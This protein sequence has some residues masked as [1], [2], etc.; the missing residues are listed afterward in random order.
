[1][2]RIKQ[3]E[4]GE[5]KDV[6]GD[7]VFF[8]GNVLEIQRVATGLWSLDRAFSGYQGE[9]GLPITSIELF[10]PTGAGKSS[11]SYSLAAMVCAATKKHLVL[12]DLEGFDPMTLKDILR[13]SGYRGPVYIA[14]GI[15]PDAVLDSMLEH[16][17]KKDVIAAIVDSVAA[18]SPIGEINSK[19][20]EANMGKRAKLVTTEQRKLIN[21]LRGENKLAIHI[22]HQ[23]P[24]LGWVGTTTPG[25]LGLHY[26]SAIRIAITCKK[27]FPDGGSFVISG[28]VKKNRYGYKDRTFEAVFLVGKGLD[29]NL[30]AIWDCYTQKILYQKGKEKTLRW[31]ETDESIQTLASYAKLSRAGE[32]DAFR[33]FYDALNGLSPESDSTHDDDT[34]EDTEDET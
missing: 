3:V 1:M 32:L 8:V 28:T 5:Y 30:S 6:S 4:S 33:P 27:R 21:I 19:S 14:Q 17:T 18:I 23:L 20:G 10:G 22:N 13:G 24:N 34:D 26:L 7:D 12:A 15:T 9:V 16:I 31:K 25:G 11:L 2:G 29:P